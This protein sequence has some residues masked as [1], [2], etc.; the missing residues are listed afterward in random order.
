MAIE[1]TTCDNIRLQALNGT[2]AG[3][4]I[5]PNEVEKA[6]Y[7]SVTQWL[8]VGGPNNGQ[9]LTT[10]AAADMF[11]A[12]HDDCYTGSFLRLKNFLGDR[13]ITYPLGIYSPTTKTY[14]GIAY[15][16]ADAYNLLVSNAETTALGG[17]L[18]VTGGVVEINKT[19]P[20]SIISF[21]GRQYFTA[22]FTNN[23]SQLMCSEG[24]EIRFMSTVIQTITGVNTVSTTRQEWASYL[25]L[26]TSFM[27][28]VTPTFN[29]RAVTLTGYLVGQTVTVFH[30][31][32]GIG[33]GVSIAHGFNTL[34]GILPKN[35]RYFFAKGPTTF[36]LL[37]IT[38]WNK[39][40][41]LE[42]FINYSVGG[43]A[44]TV[45]PNLLPTNLNFGG[46]KSFCAG[47]VSEAHFP[48]LLDYTKN[49]IIPN[50]ENLLDYQIFK[51][52]VNGVNIVDIPG[53]NEATPRVKR[54][55][56]FTAGASYL[57][58]TPAG[59]DAYIIFLDSYLGVPT[60]IGLIKLR[61]A[62]G[63]TAASDTAYNNMVSRGWSFLLVN[64][65]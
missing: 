51:P 34:S 64:A 40:I 29:F 65:N 23:N 39:I 50:S 22:T 19:N 4:F 11:P 58:A 47:T 10:N 46:L 16:D 53:I 17:V 12:Y 3:N 61:N 59:L 60:D 62:T 13:E 33:F 7:N 25:A 57:P 20:D 5:G 30:D 24:W 14:L 6:I 26:P 52:S 45:N 55:L 56:N 48:D 32:Q 1:Q 54:C 18:A 35:I 15:N 31:N 43:G 38:N 42:Y 21:W 28:H 44:N 36:S 8:V 41:N 9:I 27:R 49:Y 63:R 2:I 37:N